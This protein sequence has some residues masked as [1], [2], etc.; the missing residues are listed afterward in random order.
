MRAAQARYMIDSG[1]R[2]RI[3]VAA[4]ALAKH[5]GFGATDGPVPDINADDPRN[6]AIVAVLAVEGLEQQLRSFR[7]ASVNATGAL[8][9]AAAA[10]EVSGAA[11]AYP[12]RAVS[13]SGPTATVTVPVPTCPRCGDPWHGYEDENPD[14]ADRRTCPREGCGCPGD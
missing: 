2:A 3:E 1:F 9:V 12:R 5:Y 10:A 6:A 11:P 4:H 7:D 14:P 8:G 13:W